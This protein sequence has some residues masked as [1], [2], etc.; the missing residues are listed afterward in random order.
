ME[1]LID[2]LKRGE[3]IVGD[4]GWGTLLMQ[5]GMKHGEAPENFNL[6]RPEILTE[7]ATFYLD[8]G[9]EIIT[10][11]TFGASP[12]RLKSYSLDD[13]TEEINGKAVE[14]IRQAVGTR[15]YV[16]AS[17][18]P[19][20]LLIAPYGKAKPDEVYASFERQIRGL[21]AAGADM[22]CVET[23]TDLQEAT[24]A[25]KAARA[26]SATIPVMA[27]MAFNETPRG[28]FT[29]MGVSVGKAAAGLEGAGADIIGSNCGNGIEKMIG[30]ARAFKECSSLPIAIQ[31]NAGQPVVKEGSTHYLETPEFMAE[32]SPELLAL[33]VQVIG[34]CCG[35]T[36]DHIRALRK[37]VDTSRARSPQGA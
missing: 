21:I 1:N 18:G 31:A 20:G 17:V 12:L 4:G 6:T 15:A 8:A 3:V 7:I 11:N 36:P 28:F 16:S 13:K 27:T 5:R 10:T 30:I 24:L 32:K 29:I 33:G 22:I 26:V 23:M 25:V 2:R 35:T 37:V 9:A 14:A 19:S 34:G